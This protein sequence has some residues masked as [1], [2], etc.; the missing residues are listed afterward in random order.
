MPEGS[1][2]NSMGTGDQCR[3]IAGGTSLCYN[4]LTCLVLMAF[5]FL[6]SKLT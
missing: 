2:M 5:Y 3:H 4:E 6:L 1:Q